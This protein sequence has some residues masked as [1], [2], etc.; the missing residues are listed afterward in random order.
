MGTYAVRP[1]GE[2]AT[3]WPVVSFSG[4]TA[5]CR[6]TVGSTMPRVWSALLA[7]SKNPPVEDGCVLSEL[8]NKVV[9]VTSEMRRKCEHAIADSN[10]A[11]AG[12]FTAFESTR[13]SPLR[14]SE[15][16]LVRGPKNADRKL[17]TRL[18]RARHSFPPDGGG[19]SRESVH[20]RGKEYIQVSLSRVSPLRR[21]IDVFSPQRMLIAAGA[22][23]VA[24]TAALAT[25][26]DRP[27]GVLLSELIQLVIGTLCILASAQAF[28]RSADVAR[29]YWRWLALTFSVWAVAQGLGVYIDVSGKVA[30]EPLDGLLFFVSVIPFGMLIFLDP[31]H[32]RNRFD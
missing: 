18:Y 6:P 21:I 11:S 24:Q 12:E 29:Y 10:L 32:E 1:S 26:G 22:L 17:G 16:H 27:S 2:A 14:S 19:V 15:S 28:C 25:F 5:S 4:T 30:L 9:I 8:A 31:D 3:S 20:M 23:L 13:P 7:T